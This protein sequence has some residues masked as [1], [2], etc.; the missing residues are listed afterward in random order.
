[1]SSIRPLFLFVS[2]MQIV[3]DEILSCSLLMSLLTAC[4]CSDTASDSDT[5]QLQMADTACCTDADLIK[6]TLAYISDSNNL[7]QCLQF[8]PTITRRKVITIFVHSHELF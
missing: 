7:F 8:P 4:F 6:G 3:Q 2:W 1:M 5:P